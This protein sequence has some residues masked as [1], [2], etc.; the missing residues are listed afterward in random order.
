MLEEQFRHASIWRKIF[1]GV[2]PVFALLITTHGNIYELFTDEPLANPRPF[3]WL[4]ILLS[5]ASTLAVIVLEINGSKTAAQIQ[6]RER[7]S[8]AIAMNKSYESLLLGIA[9]RSP[10]LPVQTVTQELL[11]TL[12]VALVVDEKTSVRACYYSFGTT[13]EDQGREDNVPEYLRAVVHTRGKTPPRPKFTTN[14]EVGESLI[15]SLLDNQEVIV[16]DVG[17]RETP[18]VVRNDPRYSEKPRPY[19]GF[20]SLAIMG[21]SREKDSRLIG[22]LTVDFKQKKRPNE[23]DLDLIRVFQASLTDMVRAAEEVSAPASPFR[24]SIVSERR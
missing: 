12:S 7:K 8:M 18:I 20:A 23:A 1:A 5:A 11:D 17:K 15:Q 6:A 4:F 16:I 13:E 2:S 22:M 9:S 3:A 24:S 10:S 21:T 14:D 19:N